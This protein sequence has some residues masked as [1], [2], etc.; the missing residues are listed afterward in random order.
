MRAQRNYTYIP[1]EGEDFDA[2]AKIN[3]LYSFGTVLT[4][5]TLYP[6]AS[7]ETA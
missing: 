4:D 3:V 5:G 6:R 2:W 1:S 7:E